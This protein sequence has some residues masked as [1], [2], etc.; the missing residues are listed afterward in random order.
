HT[1]RIR[2][3][4]ESRGHRR[5]DFRALPLQA[6][7]RDPDEADDPTAVVLAHQRRQRLVMERVAEEDALQ[8]GLTRRR[9]ILLSPGE[10]ATPQ[11][12]DL[13]YVVWSCRPNLSHTPPCE[14][15]W[16]GR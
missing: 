11:R 16:K 2:V 9:R 13:R 3:H 15:A 5:A 1:A 7:T 14:R 8:R 4:H 6:S 12:R 10:D